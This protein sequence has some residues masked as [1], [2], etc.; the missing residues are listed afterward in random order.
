VDAET[1]VVEGQDLR[2]ALEAAFKEQREAPVAEKETAAVADASSVDTQA[3]ARARDEQGRF[4]KEA[5]EKQE[6]AASAATS[7]VTDTKA[8]AAKP[9]DVNAQ[10]A[11]ATT[12]TAPKVPAPPNGWSAEA[13][14]K[15]HELPAEIHAAIAQREQDLGRA[16]SKMDEERALGRDFQKIFHP[17]LPILAAEGATPQAAV[18]NL[19]NTA[20]ILRQGQQGQKDAGVAE[21]IKQHN[22]DFDAVARILG[23]T[24]NGN[25]NTATATTANPELLAL[26]QELAQL[27]GQFTQRD[28]QAQGAQDAQI[29]QHI[30]AFA[31]DPANVHY[32]EVKG[33][34]I[35]LLSNGRAK[36]LPTAYDMA[37]W[38]RPDI[39][40]S[41]LAQQRLEEEGKRREAD[42]ARAEEAR[43]K[44]VS[45]TGAPGSTGAA[46]SGDRDL[47]GELQAQ[48]AAA[49]GAV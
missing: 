5:K 18:S 24:T 10:T 21:L 12:S 23:R 20:Y 3:Q 37:C 47:R 34:M 28:A 40:S 46:G 36:D 42:K 9:G 6:A 35:A 7:T 29:K 13:K 48:F 39:R 33:E 43:R 49:R 11:A 8:V 17:Y 22:I 30:D 15:W 38:A 44:G 4:A 16:A 1:E 26:R 41:I 32:Q 27:K 45:I 25:S 19:L 14:A 31:A 2:G